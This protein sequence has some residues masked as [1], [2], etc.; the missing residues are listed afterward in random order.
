MLFYA[1]TKHCKKEIINLKINTKIWKM[2]RITS[3]FYSI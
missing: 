3:L 1:A 2:F